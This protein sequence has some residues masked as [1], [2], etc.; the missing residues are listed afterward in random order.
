LYNIQILGNDFS[1]GFEPVGFSNPPGYITLI[2]GADSLMVVNN[3]IQG[4]SVP[5]IYLRS[6]WQPEE[7]AAHPY[8]KVTIDS[9]HIENLL[10]GS[11][12][13]D[14]DKYY[15]DSVR[16][17]TLSTPSAAGGLSIRGNRLVNNAGLGLNLTPPPAGPFTIDARWNWWGDA[18]GPNGPSG[19]G[20]SAGVLFNPWLTAPPGTNSNANVVYLP[21]VL[22]NTP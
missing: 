14:L 8:V 6:W 16:V 1:G 4:G 2:G 9:N 22:N 3:V 18:A 19:D 12:A 21:L 20:A 11:H 13:I 10:G 17:G 5:G 15:G 7:A